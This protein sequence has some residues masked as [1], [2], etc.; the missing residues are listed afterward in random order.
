MLNVSNRALRTG[1][2]VTALVNAPAER[3]LRHVRNQTRWKFE[4]VTSAT[5][6]TA[7]RTVGVMRDSAFVLLAT[8]AIT[9]TKNVK[10][11]SGEITAAKSVTAVKTQLVTMLLES[12]NVVQATLVQDV[13]WNAHQVANFDLSAAFSLVQLTDKPN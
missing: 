11:D 4:V 13:K 6:L 10:L 1:G 7:E 8:L 12:V 9:A 5:V 2:E 3:L